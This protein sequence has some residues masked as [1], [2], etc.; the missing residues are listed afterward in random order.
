MSRTVTDGP[1]AGSAAPFRIGSRVNSIGLRLPTLTTSTPNSRRPSEDRGRPRVAPPPRSPAV[2]R[3]NSLRSVWRVGGT[4]IPEHPSKGGGAV[5]EG[6][7]GGGGQGPQDVGSGTGS[8]SASASGANTPTAFDPTN[9]T[10]RFPDE[11]V[12]VGGARGRGGEASV[13]AS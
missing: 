1:D 9:R 11:G 6:G 13:T 8:G 5:A 12:D 7:G 3:P 4:I 2:S 10:I